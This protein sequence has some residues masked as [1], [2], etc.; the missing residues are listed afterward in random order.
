MKQ[1]F[2]LKAT[3]I[4]VEGTSTPDYPLQPKRHS[5]EFLREQAY[6]RPRTNLYN[7]IFRVRSV[8]A[9]AIHKY[10]NENNYND[11]IQMI[12]EQGDTGTVDAGLL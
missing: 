9:Y 2:E 10:F 11:W 6:L 1:P 3:E 8:A 5:V 4:A 7:A 12:H